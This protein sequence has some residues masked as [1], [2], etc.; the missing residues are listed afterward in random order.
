MWKGIFAGYFGTTVDMVMNFS[1]GSQTLSFVHD[2]HL[3][4]GIQLLGSSGAA[5]LNSCGYAGMCHLSDSRALNAKD[6]GHAVAIPGDVIYEFVTN[7]SAE[8]VN[9]DEC[10]ISVCQIPIDAYTCN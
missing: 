5:V 8:L 6:A 1:M 4:R 9:F 10:N 2:E 7:H 3:F